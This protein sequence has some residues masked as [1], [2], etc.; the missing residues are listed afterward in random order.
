MINI[1]FK[2][3][4]VLETERL[5][6]R[7]VVSS[8]V[9]EMF[10]LRSDTEI[11]KYIPRPLVTNLQEAHDHIASID[12]KIESSE[13]INWGIT[14]KG[15]DTLIGVAGF[16]KINAE[17]Y[18]AEIG[19]IL[20]PTYSGLGLVSE[21][22]K[23][24]IEFGFTTMNLHSIE[25]VIAPENYASAKVLEKNAFTQEG[26]FKENQYFEGRYLDSAVYSLLRK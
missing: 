6:L 5:V 4:P 13:G 16:Y 26:L 19:Y 22:V 21:A 1:N 25:A 20:H 2:P 11:M 15:N 10:V 9:N 23:K 3:F 17:N 14:L 12:S 18:R 24:L 8:D 7:R